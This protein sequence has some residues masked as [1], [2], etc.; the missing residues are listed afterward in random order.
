LDKKMSRSLKAR[1]QSL[2][3]KIHR[4]SPELP[5]EAVHHRLYARSEVSSV[6]IQLTHDRS[7]QR[8]PSP[9]EIAAA[10]GAFGGN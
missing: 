6:V 4:L 3:S 1:D 5:P 10:N 8:A 7:I 2:L 9:V